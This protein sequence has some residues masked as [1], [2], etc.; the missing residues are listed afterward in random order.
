MP[1][2]RYPGNPI[3]E[4]K[5]IKPYLKDYEVIGVFNAGVIR[6]KDEI[7]LHLRVA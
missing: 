1:I 3:I 5:D 2:F 7:L 4:P 6:Y